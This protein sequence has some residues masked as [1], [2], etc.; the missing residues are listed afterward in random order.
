MVDWC[1]A[2]LRYKAG[3]FEETGAISIYNGD[4]VKSDTAVSSD[5]KDALRAAVAPLENIPPNQ[6]DWHPNSDKKVLDLVHPSLFP[7]VYGLTRILPD[8]FVTLDDCIERCGEGVVLPIPPENESAF[9]TAGLPPYRLSYRRNYGT[10]AFSRKFQW[11]PCDVE[12]SDDGNTRYVIVFSLIFY[13]DLTSR[14]Q[15]HELHQ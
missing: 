15:H 7:V 13:A 6:Q 1:I 11:L 10:K 4:V 9:D 8:T 12:F 2:E 14:I 5:L 3:I